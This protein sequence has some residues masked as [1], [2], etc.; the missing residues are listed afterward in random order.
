MFNCRLSILILINN[1]TCV[2]NVQ[3]GF[4]GRSKPNLLRQETSSVLTVFRV[5]YYM[6][7]DESRAPDYEAIEEKVLRCCCFF[8]HSLLLYPFFNFILL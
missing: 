6:L 7:E 3:L 5:L 8:P 4:R 2:C 1:F